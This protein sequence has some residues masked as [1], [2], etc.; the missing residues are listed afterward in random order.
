MPLQKVVAANQGKHWEGVVHPYE[1]LE[2]KF[3][4]ATAVARR[5]MFDIS[6]L[7]D[8][9]YDI[10]QETN[11]ATFGSCFAQHI[12]RALRQDGFN[13]LITEPAPAGLNADSAKRFNY[14]VFSA[15]TGNIYTAS[16]LRQWVSWAVG[17]VTIPSEV[18]CKDNR[19]FR[20][21]P[22][23]YRTEWLRV[24]ARV[25]AVQGNGSLGIL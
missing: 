15:R 21:V 4:W 23:E 25:V 3:F 20:S 14:E 2:E 16:L 24:R 19:L 18:W 1:N 22:T 13:W 7:W 12:G 6:D 11:V 9:R 10:V 8:P 5:N 17:D